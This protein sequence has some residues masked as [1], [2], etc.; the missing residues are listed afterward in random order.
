MSIGSTTGVHSQSCLDSETYEVNP[1]IAG[2]M[3]KSIEIFQLGETLITLNIK[4]KAMKTAAKI[5]NK[6]L[7]LNKQMQIIQGDV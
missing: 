6:M 5:T 1:A 4:A 2:R 3:Y 7:A